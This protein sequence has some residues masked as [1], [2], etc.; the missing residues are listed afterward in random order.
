MIHIR[1]IYGQGGKSVGSL[2]FIWFKD[3]LQ[4]MGYVVSDDITWDHPDAI[5]A[6]IWHRR[7]LGHREVLFGHSMGALC[8]SWVAS[9]GQPIDLIC[10]IDPSAGYWPFT[11][12]PPNPIG[13]NVKRCL[14]FVHVQPEPVMSAPFE[15]RAEIIPI[16][17]GHLWMPGNKEVQ[18]MMLAAL[19]DVEKA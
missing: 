9:A 13:K 18:R 4:K 12:M 10:A 8:A 16:D 7:K 3:Q 2:E 1:V 19:K 6:D 14:C 11:A 17:D 15:G 5:I